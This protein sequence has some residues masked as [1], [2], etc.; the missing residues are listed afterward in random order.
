M[1]SYSFFWSIWVFAGWLVAHCRVWHYCCLF[2]ECF[3]WLL[4]GYFRYLASTMVLSTGWLATG[5]RK[6]GCYLLP[7]FSPC[8]SELLTPAKLLLSTQIPRSLH[9]LSHSIS[10]S[11]YQHHAC[12]PAHS[13]SNHAYPRPGRCGLIGRHAIHALFSTEP[14]PP[15]A[16]TNTTISSPLSV[17]GIASPSPGHAAAPPVPVP[18]AVSPFLNTQPN[19]IM[20]SSHASIS[21]SPHR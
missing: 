15:G 4:L 13:R 3:M 14:Q 1:V 6:A 20:S 11:L 8:L 19:P 16:T 12:T 9:L 21:P 17:D 10:Y 2:F 18:L 7:F 5:F